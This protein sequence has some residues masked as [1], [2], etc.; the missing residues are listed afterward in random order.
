MLI[1]FYC[2]ENWLIRLS[3]KLLYRSDKVNYDSWY[4]RWVIVLWSH[5]SPLQPLIICH[6]VLFLLLIIII[7]VCSGI[8]FLLFLLQ[9]VIDKTIFILINII[10]FNYWMGLVLIDKVNTACFLPRLGAGE[11]LKSARVKF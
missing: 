11:S 9:H 1:L 5:L 3:N 10:K 2:E 7:L 4:T 6:L 8:L